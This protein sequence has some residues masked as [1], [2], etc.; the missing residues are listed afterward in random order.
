M[1]ELVQ[2]ARLVTTGFCLGMFVCADSADA[3]L[4]VCFILFVFLALPLTCAVA[5]SFHVYKHRKYV[6]D[7]WFD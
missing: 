4:L 7:E 3:T 2:C 5:L 1:R 6:P